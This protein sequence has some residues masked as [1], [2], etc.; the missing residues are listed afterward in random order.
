MDMAERGATEGQCPACRTPY[1]KDRVVGLETNFQRVAS[2]SLSQKQ[3]VTK[4]K[5]KQNEVRKDLSNVRVIQRK[6]AYIIGL[7][8]DYAYE[9]LLERKEYFG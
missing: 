4:A 5:P 3:K 8:V 7:D 6:M 1:D 9:E 2:I